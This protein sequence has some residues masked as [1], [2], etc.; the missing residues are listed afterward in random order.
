MVVVLIPRVRLVSSKILQ[1]TWLGNTVDTLQLHPDTIVSPV[2]INIQFF[3]SF[4]IKDLMFTF[5][6]NIDHGPRGSMASESIA[7]S[8][9]SHRLV[10]TSVVQL[11][12]KPWRILCPAKCQ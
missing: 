9:F 4:E 5:V 12:P 7:K 6:L 1:N 10:G 2:R 3:H 11:G 8:R